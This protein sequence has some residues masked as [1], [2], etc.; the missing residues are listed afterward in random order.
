MADKRLA[1]DTRGKD[2]MFAD[3]DPL[4]ELARIVGFEPRIAANTVDEP[5]RQEP[6]LDLED[7]LLREFERYD[8]PRP[9]V[10]LDHPAEPIAQDIETYDY[11][12][13][14]HE[15]VPSIGE[16]LAPSVMSDFETP[17][18]EPEFSTETAIAPEVAAPEP[19]AAEWE[20]PVA[21]DWAPAPSKPVAVSAEPPVTFTAYGGARDLIEEL[22]L[23]IGGALPVAPDS[24]GGQRAVCRPGAVELQDLGQ[25]PRTGAGDGLPRR[26]TCRRARYRDDVRRLAAVASEGA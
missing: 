13:P 7:E 10:D 23:S 2:D 15:D 26:A 14:V 8:A 4:A 9:L 11:V 5:Q 3:D 21:T 20:A 12:E 24:V 22:E 18:V 16:E 25:L 1:Y 6:V 19:V 17:V